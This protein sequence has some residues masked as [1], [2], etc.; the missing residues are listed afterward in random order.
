[1]MQ[2]QVPTL[3]VHS[4]LVLTSFTEVLGNNTI[5]FTKIVAI[6]ILEIDIPMMYIF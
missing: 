5:F 6:S 1:M 4:Y 3:Q 2:Y